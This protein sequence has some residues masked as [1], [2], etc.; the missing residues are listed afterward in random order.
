MNYK[1]TLLMPKTDFEMRGNLT[2]KEPKFIDRWEEMNLF[3]LVEQATKENKPFAFHD[4]PPYANGNMHIG[5]MLNKVIKD[6]IVRYKQMTGHYVHFIPGWDTHGLPIETAIQKLGVNRKEMSVADFREK[7]KEY[8]LQQVEKQ[9]EQLVRM[10]TMADY[11]HPYVT[12]DP[13]FEANQINVF[14]QWH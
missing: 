1:D 4:G 5:H 10:G 2:K 13:A 8:A 6:I 3:E 14:A 12:L 7:C 11:H 9:K